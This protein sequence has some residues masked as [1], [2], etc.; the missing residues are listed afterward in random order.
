MLVITSE[1]QQYYVGDNLRAAVALSRPFLRACSPLGGVARLE[2][3]GV[4]LGLGL[5]GLLLG[6][7]LGLGLGGRLPDS[8]LHF[9]YH[10]SDYIRVNVRSGLGFGLG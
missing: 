7:W 3:V 4:G 5:G 10:Y 2:K 1:P 9:L 6:V 8:T